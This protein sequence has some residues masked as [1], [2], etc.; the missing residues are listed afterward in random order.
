MV[1][2][3]RKSHTL[4]VI[5]CHPP[6]PPPP[7]KNPSIKSWNLDAM[8]PISI[9]VEMPY[10]CLKYTLSKTTNPES[11]QRIESKCWEKA[12]VGNMEFLQKI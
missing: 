7:K 12:H 11:M 6:P 3:K 8:F 2:Q 1:F 5:Y 4:L 9:P 10:I